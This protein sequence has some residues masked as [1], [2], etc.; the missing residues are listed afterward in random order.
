MSKEKIF[1]IKH[2]FGLNMRAGLLSVLYYVVNYGLMLGLSYLFSILIPQFENVTKWIIVGV[3]GI[4]NVLIITAYILTMV[5]GE[6]TCYFM[7]GSEELQMDSSVLDGIS[8]AQAMALVKKVKNKKRLLYSI[9]VFSSLIIW[10]ILI[11]VGYGFMRYSVSLFS[12]T[13]IM[14]TALNFELYTLIGINVIYFI[15]LSI[16]QFTETK[17]EIIQTD[18]ENTTRRYC[19]KDCKKCGGL[20][21]REILS[22]DVE[23]DKKEVLSKEAGIEYKTTKQDFKINGNEYTVESGK[24]EKVGPKYTTVKTKHYMIKAIATCRQCGNTYEEKGEMKNIDHRTF[25]KENGERVIFNDPEKKSNKPETLK[26]QRFQ[27]R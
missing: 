6:E 12:W 1:K 15:A 5:W 17:N 27:L 19:W 9:N 25:Y 23:T 3:W 13:K 26:N 20:V 21:T 10:Y 22:V 24:W 2:W 16:Y 11:A 8:Y 14:E 18:I 4:V 7:N